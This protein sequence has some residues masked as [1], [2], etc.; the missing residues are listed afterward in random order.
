MQ[1]KTS[2]PILPIFP[3]LLLITIF[4]PN[5]TTLTIKQLNQTCLCDITDSCD[6]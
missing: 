2:L 5:T 4:L 3:I 1:S 6:N